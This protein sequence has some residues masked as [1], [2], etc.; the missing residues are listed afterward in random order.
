MKFRIYILFLFIPLFSFGQ[1]NLIDSIV[2]AK[3]IHNSINPVHS[4]LLY[5]ENLD[6]NVIYNKGF[7]KLDQDLKKVSKNDQFRIASSTKLFVATII[8]QLV[9][10]GKLKLDDKASFYL[11]NIDYL[12]FDSLHLYKEKSYSNKITIGQLLSHRSGLAYIFSD[13]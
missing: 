9:E 3:I 1:T 5:V 6:E 8:L 11:K 12:D 10:E 4:I 2:K 7:G 13:K